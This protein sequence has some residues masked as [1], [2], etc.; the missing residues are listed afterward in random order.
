MLLTSDEQSR[1]VNER[2]MSNM[3]QNTMLYPA[4]KPKLW[5]LNLNRN[6]Q[7][8]LLDTLLNLRLLTSWRK[9]EFDNIDSLR[10][11][12]RLDNE[13]VR[14]TETPKQENGVNGVITMSSSSSF[15][16][17]RLPQLPP[18]FTISYKVSFYSVARS[19]ENV[20]VL[21]YWCEVAGVESYR[22]RKFRQKIFKTFI[23]LRGTSRTLPYTITFVGLLGRNPKFMATAVDLGR[24][25]IRGFIPGYIATRHVY[26]PTYGVEHAVPSNYY[27]YFE[28]NHAVEAF[29][30]LPRGVDTMEGLFTL[31]SWAFEGLH[32]RPI[33]LLNIDGYFNTLIKFLDDVVRQN[34]MSLSQR[35]LFISSFFVD[36]LLDKLE[37]AKAF[38]GPRGRE[39]ERDAVVAESLTIHARLSA[40]GGAVLTVS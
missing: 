21:S 24:E 16:Y 29:I 7:K 34:F 40:L 12:I 35:K 11:R 9:N 22:R 28:I 23:Y 27:K 32:N 39:G 13:A 37:F 14:S 1:L 3:L 2:S 33:G 25:L 30:I 8:G 10:I 17:K 20:V 36:E 18:F 19:E 6:P 15:S 4:K 38:L 5:M 26:G 31:I